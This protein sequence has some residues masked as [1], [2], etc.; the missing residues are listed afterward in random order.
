MTAL[1][2]A[3]PA[4]VI[5]IQAGGKRRIEHPSRSTRDRQNR[6]FAKVASAGE[7]EFGRTYSTPETDSINHSYGKSSAEPGS[8]LRC[9]PALARWLPGQV[10]EVPAPLA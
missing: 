3:D 10:A 7:G 4:G 1:V 5:D 8:I 9:R 6:L 2:G